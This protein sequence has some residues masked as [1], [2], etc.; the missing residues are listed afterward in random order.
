MENEKAL[1]ELPYYHGLLPRE[2]SNAMLKQNGEF[3]IRMSEENAGDARTFVLSVVY[4]NIKHYLFREENGKISIDFK[5]DNKG[6]R[7]IADFVNCHM[8]SRQSVCS[9]NN[10]VISKPVGRKDWELAHTDIKSGAKLG[11]GAFGIVRRGE[12]KLS[13]QTIKVAIKEATLT[14]CTKEQIKEFMNEARI[15]RKFK[16]PNVIQSYGV[17]VGREPLMIVMELATNGAL[18]D[19]LQEHPRSPRSKLY[20]CMGAASGLNHVHEN[21]V[22]HC[23]IAARNCLYSD[24]KVKIADFGLARELFPGDTEI[25]LDKDQKLPIKWLSPETMR[26]RVCTK[27]SDVWAFGILCWEIFANGDN[28][29]ANFGT[30]NDVARRV[31]LFLHFLS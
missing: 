8:Q 11:A 20:M 26:D 4:G 25:K 29:Y 19:Y 5:K 13:G 10:V 7:S 28:P 21:N 30:N 14:K 12:L 27:K 22:V 18:K 31:S 16:H 17:A 23:D 3:L 9:G 15:M 24:Q 1:W 6:Y 2:D